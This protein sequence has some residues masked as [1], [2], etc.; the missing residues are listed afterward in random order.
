M[1][2]KKTTVKF[3]KPTAE[4]EVGLDSLLL[5]DKNPRFGGLLEGKSQDAIIEKLALEK[6]LFELIESFRQN[7]YYKAE[8]LLVIKDTGSK[9]IVI[10]GNRRLAALKILFDAALLKKYGFSK[11]ALAPTGALGTSLKEKIPVQIYSD[12]HDLWSYLGFRHIKGA[13]EWDP[14]SKARYIDMLHSD[15]L[16]IKEIVERIGDQNALVVKM[17]NGIRVLKQATT[18]G[19][20][21]P[22]NLQRFSFSHLYTI[23][24]YANV[25]KFLGLKIKD[26]S[27]IKERPVGSKQIS[28]LGTLIDFIYGDAAGK[29]RSVIKSQNPDIRRLAA[30]LGN[31]KAVAD[32]KENMG[33]VGALENAFNT[34]GEADVM[35][36]DLIADALAKL[37]K[38]LGNLASYKKPDTSLITTLKEVTEVADY[39][40]KNLEPLHAKK[41]SNSSK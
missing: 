33:Q 10:E 20:I 24:G 1:A 30:V 34:T 27:T 17:V 41:K 15:G 31:S 12:R 8:P 18:E 32:L 2:T 11:T 22:E 3:P 29:K 28:N 13:M 5:D 37:K 6:N 36:A 21:Q 9:Y 25:Q 39:I 19:F 26:G 14:Y 23:L 35:I 38:A 7:G 16:P 40:R 4:I